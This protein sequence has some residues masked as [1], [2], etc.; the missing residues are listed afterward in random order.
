MGKRVITQQLKDLGGKRLAVRPLEFPSRLYHSTQSV[1]A[2]GSLLENY[3]C[4]VHT[5][6][7]EDIVSRSI[8]VA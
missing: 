5:L 7:L 8:H 2:S 1:P 6:L 3:T 4:C